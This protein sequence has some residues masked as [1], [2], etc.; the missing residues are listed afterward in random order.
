MLA[1]D[2]SSAFDTLSW[3]H[4]IN[5]LFKSNISGSYLKAEQSLMIDR[6]IELDGNIYN[7]EISCGQGAR[8]N[9]LI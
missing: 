7:S 4:V 1:F 9:P 5:N 6:Q 8:S 3:T 2:A